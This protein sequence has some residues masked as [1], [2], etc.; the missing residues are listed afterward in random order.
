MIIS[1]KYKYIFIKPMKVAGTSVQ[2]ALGQN[3]DANDIFSQG[4]SYDPQGSYGNACAREFYKN[5]NSIVPSIII[6]NNLRGHTKPDEIKKAIGNKIWN[7][8]CKVTIIRNPWDMCISRFWYAPPPQRCPRLRTERVLWLQENFEN[9][10]GV[11]KRFREAIMENPKMNK[12]YYFNKN[13]PIANVYLKFENLQND[14]N[15]FSDKLGIPQVRN[16]PHKKSQFRLDKRHYS[17]Y[18]DDETRDLIAKEY[19]YYIKYFGYKFENKKL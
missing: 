16:F 13:K 6:E 8:Y 12:I 17:T 5:R 3:C 2:V 4:G 19:K 14:F 9:R 1:H 10:E 15:N 18:Y 7:D 11:N